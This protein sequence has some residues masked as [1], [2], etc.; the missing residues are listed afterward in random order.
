V[1][2]DIEIIFTGLKPGEKLYEELQHHTEQ[3]LPTSHPQIMRFVSTTN[4][5]KA[6]QMAVD[7]VEPFIDDLSSAELK[8]ALKVL[9]PEYE[10]YFD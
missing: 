9:I 3:H 7:E 10:P 6:S 1:G 4:A 2:E 5:E 8:R